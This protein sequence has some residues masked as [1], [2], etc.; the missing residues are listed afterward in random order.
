MY[1]HIYFFSLNECLVLPLIE[2]PIC[3]SQVWIVLFISSRRSVRPN[4]YFGA[5]GHNEW[6][7]ISCSFLL[8]RHRRSNPANRNR[9]WANAKMLSA[10]WVFAENVLHQFYQHATINGIHW[11]QLRPHCTFIRIEH[12]Q[13]THISINYETQRLLCTLHRDAK[14]RHIFVC[15]H[16]MIAAIPLSAALLRTI[17]AANG[18]KSMQRTFFGRNSIVLRE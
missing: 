5:C 16:L 17:I 14:V 10:E 3:V 4:R 15:V 13:L 9:E 8:F 18:L 1:I 11:Q 6:N 7:K 2:V 12:E